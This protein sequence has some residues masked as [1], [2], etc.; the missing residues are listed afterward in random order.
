MQRHK[1]TTEMD[2]MLKM[3]YPHSSD[4]SVAA[5]MGMSLYTI[6]TRAKRLKLK[7]SDEYRQVFE[8]QCN[9]RLQPLKYNYKYTCNHAYFSNIDAGEKAYWLGWLWSDGNIREQIGSY[10]IKLELHQNDIYI[11]E[12]FKR[13]INADHPILSGRDAVR[14]CTTSKQM[15]FDVQK[16]GIIPRKSILATQPNLKEEFIA[17]FIRGVFD[18]D[19]HISKNQQPQIVILGTEAFCSWLQLVAQRAIEIKGTCALKKNTTFRWTLSG[20]DNVSAFAR[21]MYQP[22][23]N[24]EQVIC[25]E[26]KYHRFVE[27][28]LL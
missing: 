22:Y 20:R 9:L 16:Y 2:E 10:Q 11:L 24:G 23:Q 5:Q 13:A 19:G 21:W 7:K 4:I 25:L 6:Q 27:A 28:G 3:Y 17:D 12:K 15:F 26:R 18:G 14:L 8:Q 1:W